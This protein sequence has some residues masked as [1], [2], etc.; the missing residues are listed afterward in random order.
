M[1]RLFFLFL[2]LVSFELYGQRI[3][4][5]DLF[6]INIANKA[7]T[8]FSSMVWPYI[9]DIPL[10]TFDEEYCIIETQTGENPIVRS[11]FPIFIEEAEAAWFLTDG[12]YG[13]ETYAILEEQS[14]GLCYCVEGNY[15][16]EYSPKHNYC[17]SYASKEFYGEYLPTPK[18]MYAEYDDQ[19]RMT[20]FTTKG[21]SVDEVIESNR[22]IRPDNPWRV[23]Y[24]EDGYI[25]E[26]KNDS[27]TI[28][29]KWDLEKH[30]ISYYGTYIKS[31]KKHFD[32][33]GVEYSCFDDLGRWTKE[34]IYD[35]DV[36]EDKMVT[37]KIINRWFI[38]KW[39]F[40]EYINAGFDPYKVEREREFKSRVK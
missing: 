19:E 36:I 26:V 2:C 20:L 18:V 8:N 17:R 21:F 24:S 9:W 35:Y 25:R 15:Y 28:S 39:E 10:S 13:G 12:Y 11:F 40:G 34:V 16:V 1:K 7:C 23:V 14:R 37:S 6:P 29:L 38:S 30:Y 27:V 3:Q 32:I 33:H 31:C 22:T 5:G 4:C